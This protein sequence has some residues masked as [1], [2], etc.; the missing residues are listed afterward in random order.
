MKLRSGDRVHLAVPCVEWL[1]GHI[2]QRAVVQKTLPRV[3]CPK[4]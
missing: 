4:G 2:A 3:A 1:L